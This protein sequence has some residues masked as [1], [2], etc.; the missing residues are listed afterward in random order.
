MS[1]T[2]PQVVPAN[3]KPAP[4]TTVF[5]HDNLGSVRAVMI[6]GKP[7]FAGK[8]A[9]I[10][11]GFIEP[12]RAV[13]RLVKDQDKTKS[14]VKTNGGSQKMWVINESGLWSLINK[15]TL[16]SIK[17]FKNWIEFDVLPSL[18][19]IDTSV[20]LS[21]A[22]EAL[23]SVIHAATPSAK[24]T[25]LDAYKKALEGTQYGIAAS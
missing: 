1:N 2:V 3:K 7:W 16:P 25:A 19:K 8:E 17:Y 18:D 15:S 14:F 20:P 11:L 4:A 12:Y 5:R 21:A 9:A 24:I 23:L 6:D 13:K 10:M 22:D